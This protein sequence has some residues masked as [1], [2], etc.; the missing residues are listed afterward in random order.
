MKLLI[1]LLLIGCTTPSLAGNVDQME[2][3]E[4]QMRDLAVKMAKLNHFNA[5]AI[6]YKRSSYTGKLDLMVSFT[7]FIKNYEQCQKYAEYMNDFPGSDKSYSCS[8]VPGK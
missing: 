7:G 8:I 4:N 6:L 3:L 2:S 1:T 5:T